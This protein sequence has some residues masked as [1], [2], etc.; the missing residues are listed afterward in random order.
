MIVI[1]ALLTYLLTIV[2]L[3]YHVTTSIVRLI[4][5]H[6]WPLHEKQEFAIVNYELCTDGDETDDGNDKL[7][8]DL[9]R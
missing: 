9:C 8:Y 3:T 5:V 1:K 2:R 7:L 4:I 6:A